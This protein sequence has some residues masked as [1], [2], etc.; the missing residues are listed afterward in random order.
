MKWSLLQY[1]PQQ[2]HFHQH[3]HPISWMGGTGS[4]KS[5]RPSGLLKWE[6]K[7]TLIFLQWMLR[8]LQIGGSAVDPRSRISLKDMA[9]QMWNLPHHCPFSISIQYHYNFGTLLSST[10]RVT[11]LNSHLTF[12]LFITVLKFKEQHILCPHPPTVWRNWP[13]SIRI[14]HNILPFQRGVKC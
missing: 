5:P 11:S 2:I 12:S 1:F 7:N 8:N 9:P 3:P 4:G 6:L 14:I 13:E 10:T